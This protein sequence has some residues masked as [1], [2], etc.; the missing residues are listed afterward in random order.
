M[1]VNLGMFPVA[2]LVIAVLIPLIFSL[3]ERKEVKPV[4]AILIC[5][6][7]VVVFYP[8][9]TFLAN[10]EPVFGYAAGKVIL[11]V[12][13]PVAT[14]LYVERWNLKDIFSNLGIRKR[15]LRKSLIYG[16]L[17]AI[18]TIA[19][20]VLVATS[21]QFDLT[22][23]IIMFFEAFTE[24]FFFRGFLFL[25]LLRKT[26]RKIA[27]VTSILGFVLIHPQHFL[28]FFLISTITQGILLTVVADRTKNVIGPWVS[29]GLNRFFPVLIRGL[30]GW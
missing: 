6:I 11:F 10:L 19:I 23:R 26:S 2:L 9:T 15:G 16:L 13:F 12:L 29:H 24:E 4:I 14:I 27:Y 25:Y 1:S 17:A 3:K 30:I 7:G 20:T 8:L 18:V 5:S 21:S 22:Y 28:S